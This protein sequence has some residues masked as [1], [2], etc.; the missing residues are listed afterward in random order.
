MWPKMLFELLPHFARLMPMADKYLSTRSASE[1]AQEAALAALAGDVR[2]DLARS[3]DAQAGLRRQMQEHTAQLGDVALDVT[4]VRMIVEGAEARTL[5]LEASIAEADAKAAAAVKLL[6]VA[7]AMLS[8][9]VALLLI[10]VIHAM[11]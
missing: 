3:T 10:L 8:A 2:G 7:L 1:K 9:A 11:R 4:R 5:R 6:R